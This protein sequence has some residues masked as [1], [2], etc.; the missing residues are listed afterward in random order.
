[1]IDPFL[2]EI[3]ECPETR[4]PLTL[5]PPELVVAINAAIEKGT[6][7]NKGGRRVNERIESALVRQDNEVVYPVRDGVPL[8]LVDDQISLRQV[9]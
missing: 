7:S 5:G 2:L 9:R 1:V 6:V 4:K 3:L 8:L